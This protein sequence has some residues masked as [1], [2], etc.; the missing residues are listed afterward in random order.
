MR[1]YRGKPQ[2]QMFNMLHGAEPEQRKEKRCPACGEFWPLDNEFFQVSAVSKDGWSP[3]CIAC[4]KGKV[5]G[6]RRSPVA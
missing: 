6:Y 1:M 3:R 4:I 5:W 2:E